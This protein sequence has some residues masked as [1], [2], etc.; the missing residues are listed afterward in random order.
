MRVLQHALLLLAASG[1]V[2]CGQ[3]ITV[4]SEFQRPGPD[5]GVVAADQ[6]PARR[7]ILSPALVRNGWSSFLFT[8]EAPPGESYTIYV[9]QNPDNTARAVL[10]QL[11]YAGA[12]GAWIPDGLKPLQ[13]PVQAVLS[14]GQKTQAYL[15]DLFLP[16]SAPVERFRLEIQLH[17]A[18]RWTIYPMEMRPMEAVAP[19]Q[20]PLR[21]TLAPVAARADSTAA[22]ALRAALCGTGESAEVTLD[23]LR[24]VILRN[25]LQDLALARRQAGEEGKAL[26]ETLP[27][28]GGWPDREAFCRA[29]EPAPRGSEWWLRVRGFLYQGRLWLE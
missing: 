11:E 5:G 9:A 23:T 25:T 8:V 15:L 19:A 18:N 1:A 3:R 24:A 6:T 20:P 21:G 17:A 28:A 7:E 2:L 4:L 14:E 10:Y 29:G 22:Q 27:R 26:L 16:E 13:Q 12:G